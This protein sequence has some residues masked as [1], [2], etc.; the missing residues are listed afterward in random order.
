[1]E[2]LITDT[3]TLESMCEQFANADYVTVDTEFIREKTYYPKLCLIQMAS[4][5]GEVAIDPLAEEMD[6][7]PL[8]K[9]LSNHKVIK[10][11]H[12]AKQDIEIFY[13]LMGAVPA[14]IYDT[15]VAA[16]VCGH[17]EQIGYESLV[18]KLLRK[19]LD[20]ASR[21]TD[22]EQRPLTQRQLDYA[23]E[24]VTYLREVYEALREQIRTQEREN[25]ITEELAKVQQEDSYR[26]NPFEVWRK[27][28][29]K[30]RSPEY[31]NILRSVAAWREQTAQ[32]KDIPRTRLMKDDILL[33]IAAMNPKNME[34]LAQVR[35]AMKHLSAEGAKALLAM[36]D[37]ARLIEPARYPKDEKKRL[38]LA[39]QQEA[40]VDILKLL[41]KLKSD[42]ANV[43]SKL[44]ANKDD[45]AA[46]VLQENDVPFM[47]GWRYDIF[48]HLAQAFVAGDIA[49]C[50]RE[51]GDG[52]EFRRAA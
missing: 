16:M 26:V 25:W 38:L 29:Y 19:P 3:D 27:L 11:F 43:A 33:Q 24:D 6:L 42:E 9:L 36:M 15:Q 51:N 14:P 17:G 47:S 18:N 20:K 30:N 2:R 45:L 10:V 41:L 52:V 12:A 13:K 34:E 23:I 35:G 32:R 7:T 21:Y 50:A 48:G 40:L 49:L 5:Y 46:F 44:I 31:L 4:T 37:E 1:M 39:P 28:K 22:W 8:F